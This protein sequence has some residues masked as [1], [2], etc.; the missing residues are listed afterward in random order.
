M[1]RVIRNVILSGCGAIAIVTA[2]TE[3]HGFA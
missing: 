3:M 1:G 2:V